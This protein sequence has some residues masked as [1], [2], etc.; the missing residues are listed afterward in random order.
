MSSLI[1]A[2]LYLQSG[3]R[4]SGLASAARLQQ[5]CHGEVIFNT[6]MVGYVESL[7][8]PSYAGQILCFTYPLIGNYGVAAQTTWESR[9]IQV[10]G[11]ILSELAMFPTHYQA[12]QSLQQWLD[13]QDIPYL[14]GV[15]TRALTHTL[16]GH[17]VVPG[18]ITPYAQPQSE[19]V[20]F[21]AINW[22]EQV[23]IRTP[24]Y[25]GQGNKKIIVVDCGIKE[26]IL[27]CLQQFP[28][29]IKR[30]P[31]DYDYSEEAFD[32]VFISNGPGDPLRCTN[33]KYWL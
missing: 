15:D 28:I 29:Q 33:V 5:E 24:E 31:Y 22:V 23:S 20:A 9:K 21:D 19:F 17:G 10:K 25:F 16:R 3:E 1:P 18:I 8:D 30:V 14:L 4:Y 7:T 32:G 6:G 27:R 2:Q 11:V 12:E 26:N 13:Q